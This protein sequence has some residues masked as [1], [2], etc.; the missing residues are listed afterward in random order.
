MTEKERYIQVLARCHSALETIRASEHTII[1]EKDKDIQ[2]NMYR[3]SL[4]TLRYLL[5]VSFD[6]KISIDNLWEKLEMDDYFTE[7]D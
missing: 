7:G 1:D 2:E 6:D 3:L 5:D 4:K